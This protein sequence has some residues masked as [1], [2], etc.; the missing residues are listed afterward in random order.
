M[1]RFGRVAGR[2]AL[3]CA[4]VCLLALPVCLDTV[5]HRPYFR[6]GYYQ[7]TKQRLEAEDPPAAVTTG[8]LAVGFG[9]AKLTPTLQAAVEDPKLGQF[10]ALPL[11]GFG[12]RHGLPATGVHDD[13]FV[14]AI[15]IRVNGQIGV[16]LG[17]DALIIP[18]EVTDLA[19]PEIQRDLGLGRRQLYLS[20]THSHSSLGGWGEGWVGEAFAGPFNPGARI[21]MASQIVLAV[22]QALADLGPATM[23]QGAFAAPEWIRNR[24]VGSLG[25]VDDEFSF[26]VFR[27]ADGRSIVLGSFAAHATV[28]S[29][30]NM[31]FSADYPGYWQRA[32]E[33]ETGGAAIF[34]AGAVGSHGPV[35]KGNGFE[36]AAAMGKAL[37]QALSSRLAT[38]RMTNVIAFGM[39][40][41]EL[42][43]PPLNPRVSDNVRLRP[44]LARRL[45]PVA[46]RTY[47]QAFRLGDAI[48]ISTPCDFSGELAL[49]IKNEFARK[50]FQTVITSFNGDYIG[51]VVSDRYY[52]LDGYE[53]RLMS[54]FGPNVPDYLDEMM[55]GLGRKL[56][57]Q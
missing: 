43:L 42:T 29:G 6:A 23:G 13:L 48:W 19:A 7:E 18:R 2:F 14:K 39:N 38:T 28:L 34:L 22:R 4:A 30:R 17:A 10:R 25:Q 27:K 15:A 12:N 26:A 45:L 41:L 52:H 51:Y 3:G 57:P 47:V 50:G 1:K 36:A 55:R 31:E 56:I 53:P 21:W 16:M 24:L 40:S 44:W 20:A 11:A 32:L 49:P 37:A 9:R 35:A 8:E 46:D 54:F 33:E 5:D